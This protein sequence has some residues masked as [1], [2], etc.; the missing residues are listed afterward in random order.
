MG[1]EQFYAADDLVDGRCPEHGTPTEVV[2]EENW[3]FR[4]S[5]YRDRLAAVIER[6]ELAIVPEVFRNEVLGFLAGGLDDISVSRSR[7]RAARLG[8]AVPGDPSQVIYV[9][10]DA[11]GQ[12]HHRAR[13][14]E[15]RRAVRTVVARRRGSRARDREGHPPLPRRVLAGNP[16]L[17][18]RAPAHDALRP[19][20]PDGGRQE[21]VEV[22]RQRRRS[23]RGGRRGRNRRASL[24]VPARRARAPS[25][26][27]SPCDA[28]SNVPTKISRTAWATSC[29]GS[30]RW[31]TGS[32]AVASP[33]APRS[34]IP[35]RVRRS[36]RACARTTSVPRWP[37]FELQ[38]T[39][40]TDASTRRGRGRCPPVPRNSRM[41]S[42]TSSHACGSSPGCSSPSCPKPRQRVALALTSGADG[43]LR[44][45]RP[46][47]PRL[48]TT[49][50][51]VPPP[52][53]RSE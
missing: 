43:R 26:P 40:R 6:G 22:E 39:T 16:A 42:V 20:V 53:V 36:T 52:A 38:S 29:T 11:L 27:T 17:R 13:L 21:A 10:W 12:L 49:A 7:A 47:V 30:S 32:P 31:C 41:L 44:A 51:G 34:A 4:L 45:A 48:D 35:R 2:A 18:G 14:R 8:L 9:W 3:F 15:R 46:L 25:T 33:N 37:W 23:G 1:C 24:V 28:S 50:A 5:R 19:P